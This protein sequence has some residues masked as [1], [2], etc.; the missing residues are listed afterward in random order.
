[1]T[2]TDDEREIILPLSTR[3]THWRR[4]N[5]GPSDTCDICRTTLT[6]PVERHSRRCPECL[7]HDA[8]LILMDD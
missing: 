7:I 8:A 5:R 2:T 4:S 3:P 1:M 6:K